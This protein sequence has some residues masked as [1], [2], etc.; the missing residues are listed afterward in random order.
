MIEQSITRRT[1]RH[2]RTD[3]PFTDLLHEDFGIPMF[4]LQAA[5]IGVPSV[6]KKEA[7]QVCA[8]AV[9]V[10]TN[11]DAAGDALRSWARKNGRGSYHPNV[12]GAPLNTFEGV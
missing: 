8:W 4:S 7:I 3:Y 10:T 11:P 1:T 9:R 12:V 2:H 5:L 6:P